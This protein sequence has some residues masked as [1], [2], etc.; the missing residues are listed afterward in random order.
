MYT[1]EYRTYP[2]FKS[3]FSVLQL[4]YGE[5]LRMKRNTLIRTKRNVLQNYSFIIAVWKDRYLSKGK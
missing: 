5:N 3:N 2:V 4:M 1:E